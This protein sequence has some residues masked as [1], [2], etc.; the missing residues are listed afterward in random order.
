VWRGKASLALEGLIALLGD[1]AGEDM[2][3][4]QR[5]AWARQRVVA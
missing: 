4:S 1:D 2:P 3:A 5:T